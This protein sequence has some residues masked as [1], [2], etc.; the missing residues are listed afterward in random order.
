MFVPIVTGECRYQ[1]VEQP[2]N[3]I[4]CN[5]YPSG[6]FTTRCAVEVST[7]EGSPLSFS[8]YS[9]TQLGRSP[10]AVP[11]GVFSSILGS[12]AQSTLTIHLH[13][14]TA[15]DGLSDCENFRGYFC[16]VRFHNGTILSESQEVYL[17]PRYAISSVFRNCNR[18]SVQ[19][20]GTAV[21]IDPNFSAPTELST[22]QSPLD[23]TTTA[24]SSSN[25]PTATI[26][27]ATVSTKVSTVTTAVIRPSTM[28]SQ[29]LMTTMTNPAD[30]QTSPSTEGTLP[31]VP[32]TTPTEPKS[33]K[34]EDALTTN[35]LPSKKSVTTPS[36][37]TLRTSSEFPIVP[38]TTSV[39]TA[40]PSKDPSAKDTNHDKSTGNN[41]L[42]LNLDDILLYSAIG[43]AIVLIVIVIM[44]LLC[45]Y[46][47]NRVC[48][49]SR[50]CTCCS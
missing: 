13:N 9:R 24:R 34:D 16:Q 50:Y 20:S 23:L 5:P 36:S 35:S 8:W 21:C 11:R 37:L 49:K 15:P 48:Q 47:C 12:K 7:S 22:N 30:L 44:L 14:G 26:P 2:P 46:L 40:L 6:R 45:L 28:S 4:T 3:F 39:D 31:P 25:I 27:S 10:Q 32:F 1:F 42:P 17:F 29:S 38:L 33:P 41:S 43:A 18:Q 19:S